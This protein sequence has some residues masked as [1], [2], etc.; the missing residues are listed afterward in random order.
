MELRNSG[1][2]FD[3]PLMR[4]DLFNRITK[5]G[6][7]KEYIK[8]QMDEVT[9]INEQLSPEMVNK[10]R[11]QHE[12][13]KEWINSMDLHGDKRTELLTKNGLSYYS[14]DLSN[15]LLVYGQKKMQQNSIRKVLPLVRASLIFNNGFYGDRKKVV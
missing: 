3:I 7:V 8:D 2:W 9:N 4:G 5:N 14:R 10:E 15:I 13:F 11:E 6:S 12:Q 1:E